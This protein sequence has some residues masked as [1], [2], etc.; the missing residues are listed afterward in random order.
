MEIKLVLSS[1]KILEK[2]FPGSPRG[3]DAL[4]VD[5]FLDEIIKDYR[6]VEENALLAK[7]ELEDLKSTIQK[8]ENDKRKLEIENS[9]LKARFSNIKEEDMVNKDNINLIRRIR[10]LENF[11]YK[12]GFDPKDIQ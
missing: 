4:Q 6:L 11:L 2:I 5:Q 7:K 8:L 3:Y 10:T 12:N 1:E 9:R